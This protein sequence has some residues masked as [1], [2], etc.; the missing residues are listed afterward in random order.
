MAC[1]KSLWQEGTGE[2]TA[3]G[4]REVERDPGSPRGQCQGQASDGGSKTAPFSR[5]AEL[6]S[7]CLVRSFHGTSL[8]VSVLT[9]NMK[10]EAEAA[11]IR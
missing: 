1:A 5:P 7:H 2:D 3:K 9:G 8:D 11:G 6:S 4:R 10:I